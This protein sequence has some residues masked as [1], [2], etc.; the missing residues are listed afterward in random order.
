MSYKRFVKGEG[1][2]KAFASDPIRDHIEKVEVIGKAGGILYDQE[3]NEQTGE[4]DSFVYIG[5]YQDDKLSSFVKLE[6]EAR[7]DEIDQ[8]KSEIIDMEESR[9][10]LSIIAQAY[11]KRQILLIEGPTSIG[12]TYMVEKFVELVYGRGE[13]PYNFYCNAQTDVSELTAKYVPNVDAGKDG[14]PSY[15]LQYGA[16]PKAMGVVD[17]QEQTE[18][19]NKRRKA[20][21]DG[22]V[23]HIQEVGLAEPSVIN[24]LLELRGSNGRIAD[25]IQLWENAGSVIETG[26]NFW[27]VMSTNPPEGYIDRNPI[28]PALVRGSWYVCLPELSDKSL[29]LSATEYIKRLTSETNFFKIGNNK[30]ATDIIGQAL[31]TFHKKYKQLTKNGE[32]GRQQQIP[33]TLAN[34]SRTVEYICS[35]QYISP[36]TQTINL[37]E[38]I[39]QAINRYYLNCLTDQQTIDTLK[40]GLETM[41]TGDLSLIKTKND[42][43]TVEQALDHLVNGGHLDDIDSSIEIDN[44]HNLELPKNWQNIISLGGIMAA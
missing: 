1:C 39:R 17:K 21:P 16:L 29:K 27:A 18:T 14:A 38:T 25:S 4:L 22:S 42:P 43:I 34:I 23:L 33:T 31:S 28:D 7:K 5:D 8:I 2:A 26:P 20:R 10:L 30:Q 19:T 11:D 44:K 12:K 15:K 35:N 6:T 36:K 40:E 41:L 13:Q 37:T 24:A 3:N 32:K 9:Q